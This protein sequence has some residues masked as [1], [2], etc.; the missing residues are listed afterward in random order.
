MNSIIKKSIAFITILTLLFA[1]S[2]SNKATVKSANPKKSHFVNV[3]QVEKKD[4]ASNIIITGTAK[5]NVNST[6]TSPINGVLRKLYVRE[7]QKV[8]KGKIIAVINPT[9]RIMLIAK[10]KQEVNHLKNL[11]NNSDFSKDSILTLLKKAEEN[12]NFSYK[13]YNEVSVVAEISGIVSQCYFH[14]GSEVS[15]KDNL[16]DIYNPSS[17]VIKAEVNEKYFSFLKKRKTLPIKLNAYPNQSFTG[18]IDLVYPKID[19]VTR[20][21][22][23]DIKL[24][25]KVTLLEGMMAEI[26]LKTNEH[27]KVLNVMDDALLTDINN[28]PFLYTIDT[29]TELIIAKQRNG[30]VGTVK[31]AFISKYTK[32]EPLSEWGESH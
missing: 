22:Y 14:S 6:I 29:E 19:P 2:N 26:T 4:I 28:K 25:D 17:I 5:S 23:F 1:C 3:A 20:S 8:E 27:K 32:F 12:L 16:L 7:N 9:E 10:N 30:P 31:I 24:N 18:N 15:I 21:V 11:L 13:M